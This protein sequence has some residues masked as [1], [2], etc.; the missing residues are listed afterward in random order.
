MFTL[1]ALRRAHESSSEHSARR[2]FW[3]HLAQRSLTTL[4]QLSAIQC[5]TCSTPLNACPDLQLTGLC[6]RCEW[7]CLAWR[8]RSMSGSLEPPWILSLATYH[9]PLH[10]RLISAKRGSPADTRALAKLMRLT[11]PRVDHRAALAYAKRPSPLALIPIPPRRARLQS[12]GG[13]LPYE[14]A[15]HLQHDLA[16]E[17]T[18]LARALHRVKESPP[19]ATLNRKQRAHAQKQ[20]LRATREVRDRDICLIDDVC[21]TGATLEEARRACLQAGARTV[22]ALCLFSAR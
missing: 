7:I 3:R 11:P 1:T 9:G 15:R 4:A 2:G 6:S 12:A 19:Q 14:L 22:E 13:S 5:L 18:L 8:L 20:S 10:E 16:G 17:V 21:T